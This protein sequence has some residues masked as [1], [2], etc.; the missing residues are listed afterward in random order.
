MKTSVA[1]VLTGLLACIASPAVADDG[2]PPGE[3]VELTLKVTQI[4]GEK[5]AGDTRVYSMLAGPDSRATL[6]TGWRVPIPTTSFNT[7]QQAGGAVVPIT[8]FTYQNI[9]LD[10][11]IE[12]QRLDDGRIRLAGRVEVSALDGDP[13]EGRPKVG[14]FS[15]RFDVTVLPGE[16]NRVSRVATPDGGALLLELAAASPPPAS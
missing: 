16:S 14:T 6:S 3:N 10:S 7:A 12:V 1:I 2:S 15:H 9:G 5:R 8:S 13:I 4:G 11:D